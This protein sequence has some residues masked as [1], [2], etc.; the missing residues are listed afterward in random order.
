MNIL[1][2]AHYQDDGSPYVSFV[3]SQTVEYVR[4]GHR[5][6]V[7]VP[8]VVGKR[9][10]HLQ[11]R[12]HIVCDGVSIYYIHSLSFSNYGKYNLNNLCCFAVVDSFIKKIL[13]KHPI[14]VIH[15]HTLVF[16]GYIAVKL[17]E[18]YH[19]PV[20]ITSHG[21]EIESG[22]EDYFKYIFEKADCIVAV[23]TKL[24]KMILKICPSLTIPVISN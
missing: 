20:V 16:D 13:S 8:T 12:K 4:Q 2:I 22:R 18:K 15:A 17:K 21:S 11:K 3:H 19:I 1:V 14:D 10:R 7:I 6:I 23:S 24:K 5:V 9:Y